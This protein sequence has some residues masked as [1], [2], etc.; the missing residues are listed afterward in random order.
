MRA[1]IAGAAMTLLAAQNIRHAFAPRGLSLPQAHAITS[2]GATPTTDDPIPT[3][4]GGAKPNTDGT[5]RGGNIP[6]SPAASSR[7]KDRKGERSFP[8]RRRPLLRDPS[9]PELRLAW[10]SPLALRRR[11]RP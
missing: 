8:R 3:S 2:A 6:N 4:N 9:G 5:D 7:S 1:G 10:P 11:A